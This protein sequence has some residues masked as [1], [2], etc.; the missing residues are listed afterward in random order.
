MAEDNEVQ[1]ETETVVDSAAEV[2][3]QSAGSLEPTT[4]LASERKVHH[5]P[6]DSL[7]KLK[8][9]Q[10]ERGK[11]EAI[12]AI[13]TQ[14]KQKGFNSLDDLF[15]SAAAYKEAQS[16][17]D[18]AAEEREQAQQRSEIAAATE[19]RKR[20][21]TERSAREKAERLASQE[22]RKARELQRQLDAERADNHLRLLFSQHGMQ[23]ADYGLHLLTKHLSGKSDDEINVFDEDKWVG[24]LKKSHPHLFGETAKP[25][26]TGTQGAGNEKP[27]NAKDTQNHNA[28]AGQF[29][30]RDNKKTTR[31]QVNERIRQL[32]LQPPG[33]GAGLPVQRS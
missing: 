3:S 17:V 29:D 9:A 19:E 30:A 18:A 24:G 22:A 8:A 20:Y 31:D 12:E 15:T 23:D 1:T 10:R 5:I 26:T 2:T 11:T 33:G 16:A 14:A 4:Q 27:P 28:G 6:Q 25:A 21:E 13:I 32:G 7:K